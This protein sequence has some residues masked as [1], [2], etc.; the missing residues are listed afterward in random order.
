[1]AL[2]A[3][4]ALASSC[5]LL[6]GCP[7][8]QDTAPATT[9]GSDLEI[10]REA[11]VAEFVALL[12]THNANAS[13]LA[14]FE[15]TGVVEIRRRDPS[16]AEQ[17]D[18]CDIDVALA[19]RGRGSVR[20]KKLSDTLAWIGSDGTRAWAFLPGEKPSRAVVFE[21]VRDD[22]F[23]RPEGVS[24]YDPWVLLTPESLR[25]LAGFAEVPPAYRLLRLPGADVLQPIVV[26][27]EVEWQATAALR[28]SIR[29]G[30]DRRVREV[31]LR[32]ND[33]TLVARSELS[34]PVRARADNL[35]QG[36]WPTVARKMRVQAPR[37]E[38]SAEIFLG[39]CFAS[40]RRTKPHLFD[41][42]EM[43]RRLRPEGVE[44][45]ARPAQPAPAKEPAP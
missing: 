15:S 8:K 36:A 3:R 17:F 2:T 28:A 13:A 44:Y 26:R 4:M 23:G 34:E 35:A 21:G 41:F 40:I 14:E 22:A 6:A 43:L 27:Y 11:A 18:Q 5:L 37:L 12:A 31:L 29:F 33:G 42:D 16:G 19:T 10:E 30:A 9:A 1:M 38:G 25:L 32:G 24:G 7:P 45:I 20:L 39:E